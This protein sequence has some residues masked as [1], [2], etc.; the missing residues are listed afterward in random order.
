MTNVLHTSGSIA[1]LV[2]GT[3][4]GPGDRPVRGLGTVIDAGTEELTFIGDLLNANRWADSQAGTAIVTRGI[5]VRG[6]DPVRR[7]LIEVD[8]ADLA[9]IPVLELFFP[10]ESLPA[11][12]IAPDARIDATATIGAGA[13]IGP[14]AV[15]GARCVIGTD[16]SI[17]ANAVIYPDAH[18]GSGTL[19]HANAVIRERCSVGARCVIGASSVIGGDGFGYRP[20]ADG[21]S[22]LRI[23]HLGTVVLEDDVEIGSGSMI[24]RGKFAATRIGAGSKI[25]NLCQVGHNV[26]MGRL[27]MVSGHTGI[28]GSCNIGDRVHMGGGCGIGP[29]LTIGNDVRIAARSALMS[30][31]PAGETWGGYPA[32]EI[33]SALREQAAIR[34]LTQLSKPLLKL[35][36]TSSDE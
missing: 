19:I 28:A 13:R 21:K 20:S 32:Q 22:V 18:V 4:V 5:E 31:I 8:N 2:R 26:Q 35:L 33:R 11:L 25:D 16:V 34:K 6:H 36:K 12:G 24:D 14:G 30:N 7:S 29:H 27:C 1:E 23:P 17:H 10:G 3:L 9:M 15:V